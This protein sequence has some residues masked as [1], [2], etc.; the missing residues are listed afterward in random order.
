[1]PNDPDSRSPILNSVLASG[2]WA[3]SRPPSRPRTSNWTVIP[4]ATPRPQ[5]RTAVSQTGGPE[6]V[7]C[8]ELELPFALLGFVR[9]SRRR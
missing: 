7:L 4:S 8:G 3:A 6:T 1:M 5:S 2:D 9:S